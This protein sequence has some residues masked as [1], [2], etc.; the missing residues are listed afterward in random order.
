MVTTCISSLFIPAQLFPFVR[1]GI[2]AWGPIH[3]LTLVSL[4]SV[5]AGIVAIRHGAVR[6]HRKFMINGFVGLA[7]A[8]L[9]TLTPGRALNAWITTFIKA[10][11]FTPPW[12]G[13]VLVGLILWGLWQSRAQTSS[14]GRAMLS[15]VLLLI[16]S[17]GSAISI[18]GAAWTILAVGPL[19]IALALATPLS[20][21]TWSASGPGL[22]SR[23]ASWAPLAIVLVMFCVKYVFGVASAIGHPPTL[24][25]VIGTQSVL[26]SLQI[27]SLFSLWALRLRHPIAGAHWGVQ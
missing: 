27:R 2:F 23:N 8:G 17:L 11:P 18:A 20:S 4:G 14:V 16:W 3:L 26:A 25:L 10:I 13:L 7:V 6:V 15:P 21:T 19:A 12:V 24:W 1:F 5:A 9:F 22:V